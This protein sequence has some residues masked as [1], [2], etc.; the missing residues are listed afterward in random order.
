MYL[1]EG[2][3]RLFPFPPFLVE[4]PYFSKHRAYNERDFYIQTPPR[5]GAPAWLS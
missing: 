4:E 2:N 3:R 1:I 5:L